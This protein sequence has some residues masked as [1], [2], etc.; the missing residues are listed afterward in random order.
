MKDCRSKLLDL[1]FLT[2]LLCLQSGYMVDTYAI[3]LF[4]IV[5][6]TLGYKLIHILRMSFMK[7]G[8]V[9]LGDKYFGTPNSVIHAP[10]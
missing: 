4:G 9:P 10:N 5:D 8:V 3:S 7:T 6:K 1:E 2:D